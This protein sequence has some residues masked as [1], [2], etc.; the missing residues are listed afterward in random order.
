MLQLRNRAAGMVMDVFMDEDMGDGKNVGCW[1][2]QNSPNQ[3]WTIAPTGDGFFA[4]Y[5]PATGLALDCFVDEVYM[6]D[7][8]QVGA[9]PRNGGDNQ[10][11]AIEDAGDG[12]MRIRNKA[13]GKALHADMDSSVGAWGGMGKQ[14]VVMPQNDDENQQWGWGKDILIVNRASGLAL[15][16]FVCED[17]GDG[18]EVGGS[19]FRGDD[20][21]LWKIRP[22]GGNAFYL[23]NRDEKDLVLDAY[24][25]SSYNGQGKKVGAWE[26]NDG[27]NQQW[28]L[29]PAEDDF[30]CIVN[31]ETGQ[32]LDVDMESSIGELGDKQVITWPR[33]GGENQMWTFR[34]P[35]V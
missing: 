7:G 31:V 19:E 10:S 23:K 12:W 21:Q 18:K 15:S 32:A 11:W 13:T 2:D 4:F 35:D 14:I 5:S 20:N 24:R 16:C 9:W 33:T 22:S 8:H 28:R 25:D 17:S 6:S 26:R 27:E 30:F 34:F 3:T 29:E 1:Q